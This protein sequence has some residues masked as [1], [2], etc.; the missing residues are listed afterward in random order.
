MNV[1]VSRAIR[2][3]GRQGDPSASAALG[4]AQFTENE[5]TICKLPTGAITSANIGYDEE[6]EETPGPRRSNWLVSGI[7]FSIAVSSF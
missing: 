7:S 2:T 4:L 3:G 5:A 1:A 6:D